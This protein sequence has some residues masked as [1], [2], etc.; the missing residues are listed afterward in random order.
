MDARELAEKFTAKVAAAANEKNR[1]AT[2]AA[3]NKQKRTDDVD[4]CKEAFEMHI[5]QP[6][7]LG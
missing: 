2:I 5:K 6:P 4:H 1:Q 3:D 7:N